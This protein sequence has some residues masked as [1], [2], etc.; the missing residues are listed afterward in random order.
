[1][2]C[3]FTGLLSTNSAIAVGEIPDAARLPSLWVDVLRITY[4]IAPVTWV[5]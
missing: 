1:M 5:Y 3:A 2:M 4:N